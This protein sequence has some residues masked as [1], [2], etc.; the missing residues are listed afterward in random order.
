MSKSKNK[1][2]TSIPKRKR[3]KRKSRLLSAKSWIPRYTGKNIVKGYAK[4]FGA[5][6]LC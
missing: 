5:D 1:K 4:R 6:L 3:L 2:K